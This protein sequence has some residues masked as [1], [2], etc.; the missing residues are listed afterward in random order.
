MIKKNKV[1]HFKKFFS[2]FF[3]CFF[4]QAFCAFCSDDAPVYNDEASAPQRRA[5]KRVAPN[6]PE[7][8]IA[9]KPLLEKIDEAMEYA[10]NMVRFE[11]MCAEDNWRRGNLCSYLKSRANACVPEEELL[12]I[13][14]KE[15]GNPNDLLEDI[16]CLIYEGCNI[17]YKDKQYT[18]CSQG[19]AAP[20]HKDCGLKTF[21]ELSKQ[22]EFKHHPLAYQTYCLYELGYRN[23]PLGTAALYRV[24]PNALP[25]SDAEKM[26]KRLKTVL[27]LI[28][29]ERRV[30]TYKDYRSLPNLSKVSKRDIDTVKNSLTSYRAGGVFLRYAQCLREE[31]DSYVDRLLRYFKDHKGTALSEDELAENVSVKTRRN[32]KR[33]FCRGIVTLRSKHKKNIIHDSDEKTFVLL[34]GERCP[35]EGS[36]QKFL[37][38]VLC[39]SRK[40]TTLIGSFMDISDAGWDPSWLET[41]DIFELYKMIYAVNIK[42]CPQL[43]HRKTLWS[44]INK[45]FS[46]GQEMQAFGYYRN[47]AD[48]PKTMSNE[49]IAFVR[50]CWVTY[51]EKILNGSYTD[52]WDSGDFPFKGASIF[53]EDQPQELTCYTG[54]IL[55][56]LQDHIGKDCSEDEL[57]TNIPCLIGCHF[58]RDVFR[59]VVYLRYRYRKNI[60]HDAGKQTF[61]LLEGERPIQNGNW[62][63][64]LWDSLLKSKAKLTLQES[65]LSIS[66]AG[67]DPSWLETTDVFELYKILYHPDVQC[68]AR[69]TYRKDLWFF[70]KAEFDQGQEMRSFEYY[71]NHDHVPKKMANE[72]IILVRRC[73]TI[74]QEMISNG[75]YADCAE[76][77]CAP[78]QEDHTQEL[79][80]YTDK[81]FAYLQSNLGTALSESEIRTTIPCVQNNFRRNLYCAVVSLRGKSRKNIVHDSDKRTF[82][83]LEGEWTCFKGNWHKI[84]WD[85]LGGFIE[86]TPSEA[87]MALSDAGWDLSWLETTDI[88]ELHR[89]CHDRGVF[90]K[91]ENFKKRKI[92]W[93][94]IKNA[95]TFVDSPLLKDQK[96][97]PKDLSLVKRC[98]LL[99]HYKI[100]PK[101]QACFVGD[102]TSGRRAD[103]GDVVQ[104]VF[105]QKDASDGETMMD[106]QEQ[107]RSLEELDFA[108]NQDLLFNSVF[109]PYCA[110]D[111]PNSDCEYT[112]VLDWSLLRSPERT[113]S[114]FSLPPTGVADPH[115]GLGLLFD[116]EPTAENFPL[117][118]E[119]VNSCG[120]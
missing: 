117:C 120:Q 66:D 79:C 118:W 68:D 13:F 9:K 91:N 7:G 63:K 85:M 110:E 42:P 8:S 94:K 50:R 44:L 92:L 25:L 5:K 104:D 59:S 74:Y 48:V 22:A 21:L 11:E 47:H 99:Y 10:E 84:L 30:R 112:H 67:W 40:N 88:Y 32:Q 82:T 80:C 53:E 62:H 100:F 103:E 75:P 56:Y 43:T 89:L 113:Q 93:D 72:D 33:D 41:T 76:E 55:E 3:F 12:R 61:T 38:D 20:L 78:L 90:E 77:G 105:G 26:F 102:Q 36:W 114:V 51:Q 97:R 24:I 45:E 4:A 60:V 2:V 16:V 96:L 86:P 65:F 6:I 58:R 37:W 14:Y 35:R 98:W 119:G 49:D 23:I 19:F 39:K 17:R 70:I 46:E 31:C 83:L 111:L 52:C 29:E 108:Q 18:W 71:R 81:L 106:G 57:K 54:K 73:W 87:F 27:D 69:F 107:G 116:S 109:S 101:D 28:W 64:V 115:I 15:Q 34:E 95:Q 1:N